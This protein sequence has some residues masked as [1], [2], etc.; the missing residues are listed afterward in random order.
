MQYTGETIDS[1]I[2]KG[3]QDLSV[4]RENV[5]IEI[6][7]HGRKGFLGLGKKPAVIELTVN[8]SVQTESD[9]K[10]QLEIVSEN[11][12]GRES[13]TLDNEDSK[14]IEINSEKVEEENQNNL[15]VVIQNLGYYLADITKQLGIEAVIDVSQ[16][17]RVVYYNF[18]TE[19]EGLL[20]GKHGRTLNSLQ[21]L[22]QDYF[23]KHKNNNRRIRIMLNVA[24][25]RERREETLNNLAQKK[26]HEAI[27]SRS[28]ISLEPMPAFERKIIH[29]SLAKDEH[30]KTFSRGSE[31]YRYVIIAPAKA[32]Y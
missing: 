21:L 32:K 9:T 25:Y 14:N 11:Q 2:S 4:D 15:D 16:G 7:S 1:A 17:K 3:L 23:D 22:A 6:I 31:P 29:S 18:D 10:P 19:L 28:Q 27:I 20:I 30:V 8:S 26:A 12:V 5:E 24:G 13:E